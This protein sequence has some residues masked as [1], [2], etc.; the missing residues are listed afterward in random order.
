MAKSVVGV[1]TGGTFTD[2]VV[3]DDGVLRVHKV[4]S[5]PGN[6]AEA[7]LRGLHELNVGDD[8][9]AL[10]HGSTVAT[11]AVLERKG[12]RTGLITTAGFR[13]VLEIGRQTRPKLYALRVEREPPLVPRD[14]RVEVRERLDERGSVLISLDADSID[15]A[16][17][18]LRLAEVE[19]VA[20]CLLFSFANPAH[21]Q[22][23][24][25]AARAAGFHVS[26]SSEVLPEF[27]EYERTSTVVLNA[28][29]AP[30]MDRYLGEL[31]RSLPGDAPLRIMQ[32]NGGSISAA[33]ARREA[34]RTLL[35]GPAA[36]VVGAAYVAS[37]SGFERAITFD[38]GGTSTDVAL[39]DGDLAETTDGSIGDFPT[40]LP[41][42]D[43]HTVGAGGGSIAWFDTGG[44]L[45]VGPRS[46][47]AD[48]G[49]AAYG[50]GGTE[51]TVTDANVVLGRLIPDAFLGGG[52]TLQL[53]AARTAVRR[54]A[55]RLG[56]TV[57]EAALGMARIANANM[58]AAIRVISVERGHD[59]RLFTL[60]AFGGAGPLHA[61]EL[62]SALR[63]PRVLVPSTP[64]VLSAL[65]MLAAD[66]LKDY[67][68][69][70]MLPSETAAGAVEPVFAELDA[71]GRAELSLEGLPPER[72]V[73]ERYLDL[74]YAGQSY[75]LVVPY[76]GDLATAISGFHAAH[77]RRF[78]YSDP[79]ERVQVVNVRLKAR[80]LAERP[81][82]ARVPLD[83]SATAQPTS[84]RTVIFAGASGAE[85]HD[86]P[87]FARERLMPGVA[88]NGPAIITQY[89]T[90]TVLPPGWRATVDETGNLVL[91]QENG[92][93]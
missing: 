89:D 28:Y 52:M 43:I 33:T 84:T 90:T 60:V 21:E 30:I 48:P 74:R 46:A 40:R 1:D 49:P 15:E 38:M 13:D 39:I 79:T 45:R 47:G 72:I 11:N 44:A 87:I 56:S 2:F 17:A 73:I 42:I 81:E 82:I 4:L 10:V 5:T 71:R 63:I 55:D 78:G 62:A 32:S 19:S 22:A 91:K 92:N 51:P 25:E 53:E 35:S 86:T 9:A 6:P 12:V 24:V 50:R 80:G 3:S 57:E 54:I 70:I 8:L 64:G 37:A 58:E 16:I 27:R 59:P 7:I 29:V 83:P 76:Q 69:T 23:V 65:G 31:E 77:D 85:A 68:R 88:F 66:I 36:G 75:E 20:V 67:V 61:C 18:A 14:L 34:A 26:A 93:E 41:M